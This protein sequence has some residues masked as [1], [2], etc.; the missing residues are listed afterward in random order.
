MHNPPCFRAK[1][2]DVVCGEGGE[3]LEGAVECASERLHI[4]IEIGPFA[5]RCLAN[6]ELAFL[7][8]SGK[9]GPLP[10]KLNGERD[11]SREARRSKHC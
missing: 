2:I 3:V 6:L 9:R 11:H 10:H 7:T 4:G 5:P 8:P 1:F